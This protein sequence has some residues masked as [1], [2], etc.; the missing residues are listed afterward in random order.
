MWHLREREGLTGV[1]IFAEAKCIFDICCVSDVVLS[2][3]CRG[4]ATHLL[5]CPCGRSHG[6]AVCSFIL[7]CD[8]ER[9]SVKENPLPPAGVVAVL[10]VSCSFCQT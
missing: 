10:A 8:L 1:V 4:P 3:A 9:S 6:G 7:G 2:V 5:T